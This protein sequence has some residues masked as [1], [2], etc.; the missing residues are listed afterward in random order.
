ML[1]PSHLQI[2]LNLELCVSMTIKPHDRQWMLDNHYL[3]D[4]RGILTVTPK[5]KKVLRDVLERINV[6]A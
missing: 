5:G 1:T 2:L 3:K 6:A 4:N